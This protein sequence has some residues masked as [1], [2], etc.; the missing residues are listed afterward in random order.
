MRASSSRDLLR[1]EEL[2]AGLAGVRGVHRHQVLVGV[3]E[4]V[5]G[6]VVE[7]AEVQVA[8]GVQQLD[9][10]LVA[11]RHG[12][13]ELGAVDVEV[14]EQTLEVVLAVRPDRRPLDVAE[15]PL[16]GLVEVLVVLRPRADVDEQV[17]GQDVEALLRHR[18]RPTVLSLRVGQVGVVEV[19]VAGLA[20]LLVEVRRQVLGDEAVEQHA[21]HVALEV[22][23]VDAAAQIVGDAPDGLVQLG[24]LRFLG[25]WG[26]AHATSHCHQLM[27]AQPRSEAGHLVRRVPTVRPHQPYSTQV[28][29]RDRLRTTPSD[30]H[31]SLTCPNDPER[32]HRREFASR[33][34]GVQIPSAPPRAAG[35][36][37]NQPSDPVS[38]TICHSD[39]MDEAGP[40]DIARSWT[41]SVVPPG[42]ARG[43]TGA[44]TA[45]PGT[46]A[47]HE[48]PRTLRS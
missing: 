25:N 5:D 38:K 36:R 29:Q 28:Q 3:A 42:N 26:H 16:Q 13:A 27:I 40:G 30:H 48:H 7:V 35:Q 33:G 32:P 22:P 1:R 23:A 2:A 41:A 14:V 44:R 9:E 46:P 34:S 39:V 45:R 8:D 15:D 11:L 43:V 10:L 24:S 21:E 18:L 6:V 19:R 31:R 47:R 20:L 4:R 17:A 37:A 12:R